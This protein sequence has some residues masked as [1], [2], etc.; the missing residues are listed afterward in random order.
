MRTTLVA[1]ARRHRRDRPTTRSAARRPW[2]P[3]A[4][5][6][7]ADTGDEAA[8]SMA[9]PDRIVQVL[10]VLIDNAVDHSPAGERVAVRVRTSGRSVTIEVEDSGPGI[11]PAERERIFQPFTRLPRTPRHGWEAPGWGW[12]SPVGSWWPTAAPSPRPPRQAEALASR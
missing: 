6:L 10:L 3:S 8:W 2:L 5:R 9:D 11:P 12:P 7:I 1:D 4:F